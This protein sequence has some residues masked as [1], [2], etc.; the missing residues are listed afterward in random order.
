MVK[1]IQLAEYIHL[2]EFFPVLAITGPRQCGKT[3]IARELMKHLPKASVYLDMESHADRNKLTDAELFFEENIDRCVIIDEVQFYPDLFPVLRSSIDKN[4]VA[5]R[6]I[7]LGS[8]SPELLKQSSESLAGRIAY[9]ELTPFNCNEIGIENQKQ[10][11]FRGGF[12]ESYLAKNDPFSFLWR[13][14]FVS[15]YIQRDF[16]LLG[17]NTSRSALNHFWIMIA[18]SQGD[19]FNQNNYARALGVSAPTIKRYLYYLEE[20]YL[21]RVLKPFYFNIKKRLV[22]SPKVY[23]RDSGVLHYLNNISKWEQLINSVSIGASWEGYAIEQISQLL[24]NDLKVFYYRTHHGAE[25]DL[26]IV[27][28]IV[29]IAAVEIKYSS[30]PKIMKGF[31]I[32]IDDLKTQNNFIVTPG[33]D[34]YLVKS[35]IRICSLGDFLKKYLSKLIEKR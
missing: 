2:L 10:L 17:L 4:R 32:S 5:A 29:P 3:T 9:K 35:N 34:D 12:P 21:V 11:W 15:T 13:E 33:S 1:R 14:N 19:I 8:A 22:K 25:C 26:V 16:N 24:K 28:G 20:A 7:I 27:K 23:V 18:H 6:F 31:I 30:A